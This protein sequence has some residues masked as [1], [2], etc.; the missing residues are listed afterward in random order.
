MHGDDE[1]E[2]GSGTAIPNRVDD[3]SGS[4]GA[5]QSGAGR[6]TGGGNSSG[7]DDRADEDD[8]EVNVSA[9][10]ILFSFLSSQNVPFLTCEFRV[11][12]AWVLY[13]ETS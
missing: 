4:P 9:G 11:Q 3:D 2:D 5:G 13:Y 6:N 12:H 7:V 10:D 8:S 1:Y